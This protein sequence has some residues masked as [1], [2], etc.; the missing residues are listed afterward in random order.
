M[1]DSI[2]SL[3]VLKAHWESSKQSYVDNFNVLTAE[4]LRRSTAEVV[5]AE[6]VRDDLEKN[7][8][9]RLPIKTVTVLLRRAAKTG[10]VMQEHGV[11]RPVRARLSA[12]KFTQYRDNFISAYE[13]LINDLVQYA[14][15]QHQL[16]WSSEVSETC[17]HS[18]LASQSLSLL[19][20]I[21]QR[22]MIPISKYAS[23]SQKFVF[24][25]YINNLVQ[26]RSHCLDYVETVVEGH[27]LATA[28]FLPDPGSTKTKFKDTCVFFDTSFILCAI[29]H[30]G[31]SLE[32]PKKELLEILYEFG[33]DLSCFDHTL[34]EIASVLRG[35]ARNLRGTSAQIGYG[36][37]FD[38]FLSKGFNETDVLLLVERLEDDL[39]RVR[40]DVRAAPPY[41][42]DSEFVVDEVK[43]EA[44]MNAN[45]S[46]LNSYAKKRDMDSL[47][48]I[49]RLRGRHE[50]RLIERS[51]ALFVTS[52]MP[53]VKAANEFLSFDLQSKEPPIAVTDWD[54]MNLLWLK[55]PV[56]APTLPRKRLIAE[57]YAAVQPSD[58]FRMRFLQEVDKLTSQ[59]KFCTEDVYALRHSLE[60]QKLAME[61]TMGD[62]DVFSEGTVQEVLEFYHNSIRDEERRARESAESVAKSLASDL[63]AQKIKARVRE[64]TMEERAVDIAKKLSGVALVLMCL[65]AIAGLYYS[66][67]LIKAVDV[68]LFGVRIKFIVVCFVTVLSM[69]N[70]VWG[71]TLISVRRRIDV[72]LKPPILK[73]L[74]WA[75]GS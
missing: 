20:S 18:F 67:P 17:L 48:A 14:K 11:Y 31:P 5:S 38:Y 3:A 68:T 33:A 64:D 2:I 45:I 16:T 43:L 74:Q 55:K 71:T 13:K 59:G 47:T 72:T 56:S 44:R 49:I 6:N 73:L 30:A 69:A 29:G 53:L 46:Y 51:R 62:E 60:A 1:S 58:D 8:G 24:A 10:L 21:K 15:D 34:D 35:C 37:T 41:I 36:S 65:S 25:S 61:L 32:A 57:C 39:K 52:N 7:F 12:V 40:I 63:E 70:W 28:I 54:L 75:G 23:K 27:M 22:E 26:S 9:I 19:A 50:F 42:K 4:S 66:I